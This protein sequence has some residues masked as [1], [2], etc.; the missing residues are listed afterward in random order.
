MIQLYVLEKQCHFDGF[1]HFFGALHEPMWKFAGIPNKDQCVC[2]LAEA[3]WGHCIE[4]WHL[5][6]RS[7]HP[8]VLRVFLRYR[9]CT[10][11]KLRASEF[12]SD[13]SLCFLFKPRRTGCLRLSQSVPVSLS[14]VSVSLQSLK[15]GAPFTLL[16]N[17]PSFKEL[18]GFVWL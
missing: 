16:S 13:P 15:S 18:P 10:P 12:L 3:M 11:F 4:S 7:L 6:Q 1:F 5:W 14:K 17:G 9:I 8:Q 2:S